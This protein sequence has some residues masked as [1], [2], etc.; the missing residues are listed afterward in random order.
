MLTRFSRWC[1]VGLHVSALSLAVVSVGLGANETPPSEAEPVSEVPANE[2]VELPAE[3]VEAKA[4]FE[5]IYP[6]YVDTLTSAPD[7]VLRNRF[8][9]ET[10]DRISK[11][12]DRIQKLEEE[13]SFEELARAY[14]EQIGLV[15]Q[16]LDQVKTSDALLAQ[17]D[18]AE[19]FLDG[20]E[21]DGASR[22]EETKER[23]QALRKVLAEIDATS[24]KAGDFEQASAELSELSARSALLR[25]DLDRLFDLQ[26]R[27]AREAFRTASDSMDE[28]LVATR[29]FRPDFA[30]AKSMHSRITTRYRIVPLLK[31][32]E[33]DERNGD[34]AQAISLYETILDLDPLTEEAQGKL[35]N[36]ERLA[37]EQIIK[38]SLAQSLELIVAGDP[39]GALVPAKRALK[40]S[41]AYRLEEN[42]A[43]SLIERA[44]SDIRSASVSVISG[45]IKQALE[46]EDWGTVI[47]ASDELLAIQPG[48]HFA[49]TSR[50]KAIAQRKQIISMAEVVAQGT[51]HLDKASQ[52]M[53][54][55][56]VVYVVELLEESRSKYP[57]A[58][59][60]EFVALEKRA[61]E[62][63][64]SFDAKIDVEFVSNKKANVELRGYGDLGKFRRKTVPL[65]PG[66]YKARCTQKGHRDNLV[67]IVIEPGKRPEPIVLEAG[68]KF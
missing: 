38:E 64:A 55:P 1:T 28:E 9:R 23:Y 60:E 10:I 52:E 21:K 20:L 15:E 2:P 65:K 47:R 14:E 56:L 16:F 8:F 22:H 17:R 50:D 45:E 33:A 61:S 46:E 3:L 68:E 43:R 27:Q 25:T 39:D 4:Q 49:V 11:G 35:P 44:E 32:A 41:Q 51:F 63:E 37:S 59:T 12:D 40:L 48:N 42:S 58:I 66:V 31:A 57:D 36:L 62:T 26:W 29:R 5:V 53:D 13:G 34:F 19:A 24:I 54:R 67:R 18:G 30:P 7:S 6:Q